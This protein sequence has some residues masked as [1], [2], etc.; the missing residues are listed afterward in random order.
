MDDLKPFKPF[1]RRFFAISGRL[2]KPSRISYGRFGR[3]RL[4]LFP[5]GFLQFLDSLKPSRIA[6]FFVVMEQQSEPRGVADYFFFIVDQLN[7]NRRAQRKRE[8]RERY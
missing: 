5:D 8:R 2:E 3:N 6:K 4:D 7:I 1:S